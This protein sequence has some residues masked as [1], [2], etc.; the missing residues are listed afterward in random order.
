M[1][2]R[3]YAGG[4]CFENIDSN[5]MNLEEL[6]STSQTIFLSRQCEFVWTKLFPLAHVLFCVRTTWSLKLHYTKGRESKKDFAAIYLRNSA[7]AALVTKR[8]DL[9]F[10]LF[11]LFFYFLSYS[12]NDT[13]RVDELLAFLS[14]CRECHAILGLFKLVRSFVWENRLLINIFFSFRC[15][16]SGL[17]FFF[18]ISDFLLL[19]LKTTSQAYFSR[20]NKINYHS[21]IQFFFIFTFQKHFV[22]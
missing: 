18:F 6:K 9:F 15:F 13:F 21:H 7:R 14:R 19:I 20:R 16:K 12:S 10:S 4:I 3:R 2:R 5:R 1:L 22:K 17:T 8:L 11:P